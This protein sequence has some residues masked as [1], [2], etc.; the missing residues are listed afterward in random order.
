MLNNLLKPTEKYSKIIL[1]M[2]QKLSKY[3]LELFQ[4]NLR[5]NE[6][7]TQIWQNLETAED[8]FTSDFFHQGDARLPYEAINRGIFSLTAL[9]GTNFKKNYAN[10]LKQSPC[11]HFFCIINYHDYK[12]IFYFRE[13]V[14]RDQTRL[15]YTD[16]PAIH[17]II[18]VSV[19]YIC[20]QFNIYLK[21]L[22]E[23]FVD[24]NG[25]TPTY[26]N[27]PSYSERDV[28]EFHNE[29]FDKRLPKL[30]RQ[31]RKVAHMVLLGDSIQEM[32]IKLNVSEPTIIY[33]LNILK[34]KFDITSK[35][36]LANF[37]KDHPFVLEN[38]LF[39]ESINISEYL[40]TN[41]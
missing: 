11:N 15:L 40:T 20:S 2:N 32:A 26:S 7:S 29:L 6:L 36:E 35:R 22:D 4:I 23:L 9:Y 5:Y 10:E 34:D 12:I 18:R 39:S 27:K 31:Q 28:I 14:N 37:I 41:R 19:K 17:G 1:K 13:L 33:Y 21:K 30:P 16:L 8:F 38:G 3:N 25:I 24:L